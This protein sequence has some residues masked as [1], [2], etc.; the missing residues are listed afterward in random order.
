MIEL[1]KLAQM[2]DYYG[3]DPTLVLAGGGNTS[4]KT[5]DV[6]YVK[7]SGF[8][9]SGIRPNGFAKL[10]RHKL[11]ELLLR[12]YPEDTPNID[13]QFIDD[14]MATRLPGEDK[15]PSVEALLHHSFDFPYVLHLHPTVINSLTSAIN[16]EAE[17]KR[18][19]GDDCVW[20]K[21]V[22][23]GYG[24]ARYCYDLQQEHKA[25]FGVY[26]KFLLLQNH[27]IF[28]PG[29][30]PE[31]I[32]RVLDDVVSKI[33]ACYDKTWDADLAPI[34]TESY[35]AVKA[36]LSPYYGEI[37][38][39]GE[40]S[41]LAMC[42]NIKAA[43]GLL[44]PYNPDQITY[45]RS[46]PMY[47]ADIS[48]LDAD[49]KAYDAA[50]GGLPK[51]VIVEKVGLFTCG[52]DAGETQRAMLLFV[53]AAKI[54]FFASAFGGYH[55]LPDAFTDFIDHWEVESYRLGVAKTAL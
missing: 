51:V 39:C 19:F 16:G 54:A 20:V 9:L 45:C 25:R 11:Q 6:L 18:L 50:H 31:E 38:F 37:R 22:H 41:V 8:P 43:A 44:K 17:A 7:A 10:D 14:V 48:K 29:N 26:P 32:G 4:Y 46:F 24:L 12:G 52:K 34:D 42:E 35:G 36:A 53:D 30:S 2:S 5:A 28:I 49:M 33:K 47:C 1:E 3:S 13:T 15:R 55:Q 23:P 21:L 40:K 27:G